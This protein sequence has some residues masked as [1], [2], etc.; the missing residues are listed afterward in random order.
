MEIKF[1]KVACKWL[2]EL[3]ARDTL[4][5]CHLPNFALFC[6]KKFAAVPKIRP[7]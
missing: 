2:A 7:V 5:A 4:I 1:Y 6:L 3:Q